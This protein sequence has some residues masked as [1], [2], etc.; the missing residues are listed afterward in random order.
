MRKPKQTESSA[1][2]PKDW[3]AWLELVIQT[4]M[5]VPPRMETVHYLADLY[6]GLDRQIQRVFAAGATMLLASLDH[7]SGA[8]ESLFHSLQVL[9]FA[10]SRSGGDLL[11]ALVRRGALEGLEFEG[12]DLQALL[13]STA[14]EYA[15][16]REFSDY[17][18]Y[19]FTESD[20][21]RRLIL[22]YRLLARRS[23]ADA[24]TMLDRILPHVSS[25]QDAL[26]LSA[27]VTLT[28]AEAGWRHLFNWVTG[29]LHQRLLPE[30][31]SQWQR[32][33]QVFRRDNLRWRADF[34]FSDP[35]GLLLATFLH[36]GSRQFA[37]EDVLGVAAAVSSAGAEEHQFV[38]NEVWARS[39]REFRVRQP[40][41]VES[42]N[43]LLGSDTIAASR[44]YEVLPP[45]S[46]CDAY[47]SCA[48]LEDR[49]DL[50]PIVL[51]AMSREEILVG[52]RG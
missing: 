36:A 7:S 42:P 10:K 17:I 33:A 14:A 45:A 5:D 27:S 4:G 48:S 20:N 30:Y 41:N 44:V 43:S 29:S 3:A 35:Y 12:F 26:V 51:A 39:C 9:G 46:L 47:G 34:D 37:A 31:E 6:Q 40:W 38:L 18:K 52:A 50:V 11:W 24:E 1:R 32:V 8:A 2:S 28:V 19:R 16:D 15:L 49:E 22:A 23:S 21:L 13:V 25:S